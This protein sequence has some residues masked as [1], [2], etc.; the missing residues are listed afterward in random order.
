MPR[1]TTALFTGTILILV[2]CQTFARLVSLDISIAG[3]DLVFALIFLFCATGVLTSWL[4]KP[5]KRKPVKRKPKDDSDSSG[6]NNKKPP[7]DQ[8]L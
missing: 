5:V 2:L 7:R 1:L 3:N 6:D 8:A 4:G